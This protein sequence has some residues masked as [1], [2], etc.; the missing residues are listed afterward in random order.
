MHRPTGIAADLDLGGLPNA[1]RGVELAPY[2]TFGIGGPADILAVPRS[3]EELADAVRW[4]ERERVDWFV[5]GCGANILVG[6][7]GF[8]GLVIKNE[9]NGMAIA[10]GVMRAESGVIVADALN[11][12]VELGLS[13]L[14]HYIEIPSTVGGAL[15]QNL[16]FLSP[17]RSRTVFIAEIVQGAR[18]LSGA[19]V[20][21]VDRDYFQFG[22][23]FS[24]LHTCRD[25]VLDVTFEL[26]PADP[27]ELRRTI[28]ANAAWRHEKHP[29]EAVHMSAGSIFRKIA[30]VGAGRLIDEAGLKGVRVGGAEVSHRHANYILNAA[31]ASAADVRGLIARV[32]AEVLERSGQALEP[33]I[34]FVGEFAGESAA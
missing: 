3:A 33:E 9:A 18:V 24:V 26:S 28:Q 8:R 32:Q 10:D 30:D 31:H 20:R 25:V 4:A 15:W 23:D 19:E 34:S 21:E 11:A 29:P 6:D 13:G 22:Y 27:D 14:E 7:L 2:T 1:R 5:L 17:D 16:H 12:S